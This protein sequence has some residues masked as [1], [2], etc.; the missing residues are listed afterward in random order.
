MSDYANAQPQFAQQFSGQLGRF[1]Q[2]QGVGLCGLTHG[3]NKPQPSD[4]DWAANAE[5]VDNP[6]QRLRAA[7]E[8]IAVVCTDNMD[9][10]CAHRMALDFV[11]QVANGELD[12]H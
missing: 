10:D 7:L 11:R 3:A 1:G 5:V 9:R 8:Q 12:R 6:E 2:G 4:G